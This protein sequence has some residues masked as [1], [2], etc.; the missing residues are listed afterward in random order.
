[1]RVREAEIEDCEALGRGMK[2]V[3]EEGSGLATEPPVTVAELSERYRRSLA[4]GSIVLVLEDDGKPVGCLGL[5]P[6]HAD[7]V[8]ELGMWVLPA[9]R[10]R[11]GGRMLVEA[12]L[13]ARPP[14][15]HKIELEVFPENEAAIGLYEAT[16]FEREGLLRDCYR[17]R[18]GSLRSALVMGRLFES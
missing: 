1:M 9:W 6:T 14:H 10:G 12:A 8:L 4:N 15:V 5:N 16:G 7:G 11:G 3:V 18:D 17:R 13:A 2:A